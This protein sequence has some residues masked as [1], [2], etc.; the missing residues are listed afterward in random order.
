M[1]SAPSKTFKNVE[2]KK[3]Y[4]WKKDKEILVSLSRIDE[5]AKGKCKTVP[6]KEIN[7]FLSKLG[8]SNG[9]RF[10]KKK[11]I[12]EAVVIP[13]VKTSNKKLDSLGFYRKDVNLSEMRTKQNALIESKVP[14]ANVNKSIAKDGFMNEL[15]LISGAITKPI[16]RENK[17]NENTEP[18]MFKKD[19]KIEKKTLS[20]KGVEKTTTKN[21]LK[22]PN[23]VEETNVLQEGKNDRILLGKI[24][25]GEEEI[26]GLGWIKIENVPTALEEGDINTYKY[27]LQGIIEA[28][29]NKDLLRLKQIPEVANMEKKTIAELTGE[30]EPGEEGEDVTGLG[31]L[32]GGAEQGAPPAVPP[33]EV[34]A[35]PGIDGMAGATEAIAAGTEAV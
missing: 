9:F 28:Q 13:K 22:V 23:E 14:G 4:C 29:L 35:T 32:T 24:T 1:L 17:V 11:V 16:V 34:S 20:T 12:T 25:T 27:K 5:G 7:S 30:L 2:G 10:K 26:D 18:A 3:V 19:I 6:F 31:E 21:K 33:A 15:A 8:V